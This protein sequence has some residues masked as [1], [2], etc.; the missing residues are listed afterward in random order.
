MSQDGI[1]TA[2]LTRGKKIQFHGEDI[3]LRSTEEAVRGALILRP[4]PSIT[5]RARSMRLVIEG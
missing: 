3:I 2:L 5:N 4:R 1:K